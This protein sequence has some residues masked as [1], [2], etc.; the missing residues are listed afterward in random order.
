MRPSNAARPS[1]QAIRAARY[2]PKPVKNKGSPPRRRST[3]F[4]QRLTQPSQFSS[5][6]R[7]AVPNSVAVRPCSPSTVATAV[8]YPAVR[9]V[10][11]NDV[12][13]TGMYFTDE[14]MDSNVKFTSPVRT[15]NEWHVP[16]RTVQ[17][18]RAVECDRSAD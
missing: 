10:I 12:T 14:P 8:I 6:L 5:T 16:D 4:K 1:L 18:M 17:R 3:A 15:S 2:K 9:S 13:F 11:S 7:A